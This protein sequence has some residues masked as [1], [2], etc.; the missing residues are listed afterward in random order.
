MRDV[1]SNG[2]L[3]FKTPPDLNLPGE[4]QPC[5]QIILGRTSGECDF[6]PSRCQNRPACMRE[7]GIPPC[8]VNKN[9][10]LQMFFFFT[11]FQLKYKINEY[12]SLF[13]EF[14]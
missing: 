14:F 10:I 12:Y 13:T 7:R 11:V 5:V 2:L 6:L 8:T 3:P 1:A 4:T 9:L